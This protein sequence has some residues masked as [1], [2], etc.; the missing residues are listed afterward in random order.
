MRPKHTTK[1]V[2]VQDKVDSLLAEDT[3][4][5]L[6]M[7]FMRG[8][9]L[10]NAVLIIDEC[11]NARPSQIFDCLTR[12]G[13]GSKMIIT[14]DMSQCDLKDK[15]TSGFGFFEYMTKKKVKNY[16]IIDLTANHRDEIVRDVVAAYTDYKNGK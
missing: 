7:A 3:I 2:E 5:I 15:T 16:S 6:P 14:G 8:M 9:T 11:Q 4:V 12:F 10:T 1:Q 13:K